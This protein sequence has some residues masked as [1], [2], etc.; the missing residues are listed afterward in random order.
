M[1][2]LIFGRNPVLEAIRAGRLIHKIVLPKQAQLRTKSG[3]VLH[4]IKQ[5]AAQAGIL[6][7]YVD[8]EVLDELVP[9]Q[10]HQGVIAVV[11]PFSYTPFDEFLVDLGKGK[12]PLVV[13]LDHWQD[14]QNLGSLLRTAEAAGVDGVILPKRRSVGVNATVAKVAAGAL[15]YVKV[16]QVSNLVQTIGVL[17]EHGL[18]IAG[19]S[20]NAPQSCY[21]TDFTVPLG[22][23]IGSEGAGLSRLVEE[24]CD[25]LTAIPMQG[26]I[27]SLNAAVSAAI[28]IFEVLRQRQFS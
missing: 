15:E 8:R 21:Q 9:G 12:T 11:E 13:L 17:K 1:E 4:T 23:V 14:P 3:D 20:A 5:R 19:A 22:L 26:E 24:N 6:V 18:W 7:E 27:S 16:V 28:L 2:T 25:F 10:N